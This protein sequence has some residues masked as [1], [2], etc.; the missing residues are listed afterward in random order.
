[1]RNFRC[2]A[3]HVLPH[4]IRSVANAVVTTLAREHEYVALRRNVDYDLTGDS[5]I[6]IDGVERIFQRKH[7]PI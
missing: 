7:Q 2:L 3:M 1:M 5:E 4:I 6:Q